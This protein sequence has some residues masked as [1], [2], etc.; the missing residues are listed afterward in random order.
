[1]AVDKFVA[2]P[3]VNEPTMLAHPLS[4]TALANIKQSR[5]L[6]ARRRRS[7]F[8]GVRILVDVVLAQ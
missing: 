7:I 4:G 8:I 6:T 2:K 1:M 3:L 5:T